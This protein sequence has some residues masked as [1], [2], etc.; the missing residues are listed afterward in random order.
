LLIILI[1]IINV[2]FNTLVNRFV[3]KGR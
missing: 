2:V 1:F 3:A